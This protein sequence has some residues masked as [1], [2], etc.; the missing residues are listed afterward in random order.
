MSG[1]SSVC[2]T[3]CRLLYTWT[4]GGGGGGELYLLKVQACPER[5]RRPATRSKLSGQYL[6][7]GRWGGELFT[8]PY[9]L[10]VQACPLLDRRPAIHLTEVISSGVE[11][12]VWGGGGIGKYKFTVH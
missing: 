7:R 10:M 8:C 6:D 12:C 2:I 9:P 11:V 5:D 1:I 4:G 3:P